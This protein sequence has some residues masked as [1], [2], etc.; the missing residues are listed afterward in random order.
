VYGHRS[1][2]AAKVAYQQMEISY[3]EFRSPV[4]LPG[5][6]DVDGASAAY[7]DGFLYVVLP[8]AR[9]EQKVAIVVV[10]QRSSDE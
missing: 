5:E 4:Y 1:D 3:G 2:P 9:R 7:D 6:V 8:K 10:G